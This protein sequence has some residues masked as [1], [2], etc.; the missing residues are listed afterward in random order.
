MFDIQ[1]F[2]TIPKSHFNVKV[3]VSTGKWAYLL[4]ITC[5][6]TRILPD[7]RRVEQKNVLGRLFLLF[8]YAVALFFPGVSELVI[9]IY[10]LKNR[11]IS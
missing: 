10:R 6:L 1:S 7:F 11:R 3:F 9:I 2:K 5:L 8:D 4:L